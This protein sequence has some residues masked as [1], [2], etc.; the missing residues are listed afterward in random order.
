M[1]V[2]DR[3]RAYHRAGETKDHSI[4]WT[5]E[6]DDGDY[7]VA[8]QYSVSDPS[9]ATIDTNVYGKVFTTIWVAAGV[10]GRVYDVVAMATTEAGRQFIR[11]FQIIVR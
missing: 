6:L 11:I 10:A 2:I 1:G 9:L 5:V 7:I 8:E 4:D 3:Y